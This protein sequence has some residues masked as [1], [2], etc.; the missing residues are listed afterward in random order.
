MKNPL[1]NVF[2]TLKVKSFWIK[3]GETRKKGE[4]EK[5]LIL[6]STP[7][8]NSHLNNFN[9]AKYTFLCCQPPFLLK[10]RKQKSILLFLPT[11]Q[12]K[13]RMKCYSWKKKKISFHY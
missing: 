4:R 9:V 8:N 10:I 1:N 7:Q 2:C 13:F 11:L 12:R 3:I 6:N 5:C